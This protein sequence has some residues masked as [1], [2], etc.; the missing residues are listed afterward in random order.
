[1]SQIDRILAGFLIGTECRSAVRAGVIFL[2]LMTACWVKLERGNYSDGRTLKAW[3]F[4][5]ILTTA[6]FILAVVLAAALTFF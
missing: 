5:R 3:K 6:S 1:M 4:A 2:L